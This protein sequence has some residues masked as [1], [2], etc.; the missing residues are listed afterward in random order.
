VTA[1]RLVNTDNFGGDYPN[2][3]WVETED[4]NGPLPL[5]FATKDAARVHADTLNDAFSGNN[6]PRYFKVVKMPYE[7]QPGFEP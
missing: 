3:R 1:Y 5:E 4:E 7:L 2:E 6:A